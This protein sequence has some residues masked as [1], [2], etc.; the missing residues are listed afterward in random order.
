MTDAIFSLHRG[1]APL[2]VSLPHDGSAIP[3]AQAA[4]MTPEARRA[5]D[6]DWHVA[7]RY[8]F[9]RE[10]AALGFRLSAT[11]LDR[12]D[13]EDRRLKLQEPLLVRHLLKVDSLR[14]PVEDEV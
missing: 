5:P 4:R 3:P 12:L 14:R 7:R 9:A 13:L 6:P 8:A 2:L 1:S 11:R 10:L